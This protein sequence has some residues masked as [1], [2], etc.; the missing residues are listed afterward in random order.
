[1]TEARREI[2]R[3]VEERI[4]DDTRLHKRFMAIR[5]GEPRPREPARL[6]TLWARAIDGAAR[7]MY[8]TQR[9]SRAFAKLNEWTAGGRRPE[10]ALMLSAELLGLSDASRR[11]I[12][13]I[14]DDLERWTVELAKVDEEYALRKVLQTE[15][16][17]V[18][19]GVSPRWSADRDPERA[20]YCGL[21]V[22]GGRL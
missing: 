6:A 13:L 22:R 4:D 18:L 15:P 21:A 9:A 12:V 7:K 16:D 19:V 8:D 1:M 20:L 11:R 5:I 14:V 2:A 10:D 3:G 17:I